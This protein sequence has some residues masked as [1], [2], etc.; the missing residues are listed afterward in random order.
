MALHPDTPLQM[1]AVDDI[2]AYG[3][4]VFE[5]TERFDGRELDIAGDELTPPE[6]ARV[7]GKAMRTKVE[8]VPVPLEEVRKGSADAAIMYDWFDPRRL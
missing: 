4:L 5:Q 7:L 3:G 2:G 6:A 8:F 1:I